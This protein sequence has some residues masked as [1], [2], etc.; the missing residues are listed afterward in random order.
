[1]WRV[2]WDR[3][4]HAGPR[5]EDVISRELGAAK[6]MVVLWSSVSVKS[7]WVLDEANEGKAR[8]VLVQAILEDVRAPF[9]FRQYQIASLV[10]WEGDREHPGLR[11][12]CSGVASLAGGAG[13]ARTEDRV[14]SAVRQVPT[15]RSE[16]RDGV[17][18]APRIRPR[19]AVLAAGA[20]LA[21]LLV[22]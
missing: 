15:S 18:S 3:N 5:F 21:V 10:G 12:V 4:I 6:C 14:A 9:G 7:D 11:D 17:V 16:T 8:G 1:G 19:T 2:F 20:L 22:G 13:A